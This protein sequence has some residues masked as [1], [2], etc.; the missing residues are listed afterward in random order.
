VGRLSDAIGRYGLVGTARRAATKAAGL[1]YLHQ[2]HVW[3]ELPL[4]LERPRR[5]LPPELRLETTPEADAAERWH[6]RAGD[7]EAFSCLIYR[8]Q[9]PVLAAPGGRMPLPDR[10]VSLEDSVT[11]PAFR[12]RGVAPAAWTAIADAL[13]AEGVERMVTKV[14]I[15]NASSRRAVEKAG[16]AE[17]A[18]QRVTRIGP[19][20]RVAF[21]VYG[22]FGAELAH[23]LMGNDRWFKQ[24]RPPG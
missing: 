17:V 11:D 24:R 14:A 4:G 18:L 16:F 7:R 22:G 21:V 13:E 23:G 12:G 10:T 2:E 9:T 6:G 1:A 20:K 15:E 5:L 19:L 3:Y 8:G